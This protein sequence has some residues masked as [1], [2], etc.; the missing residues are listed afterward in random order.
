V[1]RCVRADISA[2]IEEYEVAGWRRAL[3]IA[4]RLMFVQRLQA[5]V[6]V[7]VAH[8][9]GR[10]LAPV[11][12]VVKW[13]NGAITGSDI[14]WRAEIGEGLRLYHPTGVVVGPNVVVG[15]HCT[16]MQQVTLGHDRGGSPRLGDHVSIGPGA[17][18]LGPIEIGSGARV[19]A[20]SV[21]TKSVPPGA[22]AF[23]NPATIRQPDA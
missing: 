6:L 9:G 3:L 2:D 12:V 17:C 11:A 22:I 20:N 15:A 10:H 8:A 21:V 1:L 4:F 16:L 14:A 7:R 13:L 19:G 23:G 18:V 5:V